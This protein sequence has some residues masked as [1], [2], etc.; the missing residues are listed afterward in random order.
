MLFPRGVIPN[1]LNR[2]GADIKW[3]GPFIIFLFRLFRAFKLPIF[4]VQLP[5]AVDQYVP[6]HITN[7]S[8]FSND[9]LMFY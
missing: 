3:N 6:P 1:I 7:L 2:G 5:V 8:Y 4:H 9:K